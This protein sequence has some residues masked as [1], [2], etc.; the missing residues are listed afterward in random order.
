MAVSLEECRSLLLGLVEKLERKHAS[1]T[2]DHVGDVAYF[3]FEPG[4]ADDG[5]DAIED[6]VIA[7]YKDGRVISYTILNASKHGLAG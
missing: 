5:S 7:A 6:D 3:I 4:V 2:Y 1:F